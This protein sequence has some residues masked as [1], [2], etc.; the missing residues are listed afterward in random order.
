VALSAG[1][2]LGPYEITAQIGVGGMGVVY[3][4]WDAK[5]QR[6]VAIKLLNAGSGQTHQQRLV[7]E[8]RAAAAL[9]HPHICTVYEV[10]EVAERIFIV[11]ECLEGP[12][13]TDAIRTGGVSTA[14]TIRYGAQIADA[15]SHAH[16][17]GIVH[18][19]IKSG[20]V[21]VLSDHRVKVVDFGLA[22]RRP[23]VDDVTRS[24]VAGDD[25]TIAG[26]LPYM[27][28]E[29]LR[30]MPADSRSDIWSLG[31]VLYEMVCGE[32][33]FTG[34]TGF[35]V[36]AAILEKT[37][38]PL[39]ARVPE[40]VRNVIGG[41]LTKDLKERYQQ[42]RDV[43]VALEALSAAG[44]PG[45]SLEG[46]FAF[47]PDMICI[48]DFDGF[49]RRVNPAWTQTLGWNVDELLSRP[50]FEFIHPDDR[51]ATFREALRMSGTGNKVVS[52]T[53]RYRCRDGSYRWL[54]WSATPLVGD[55]LIYG[56]ARAVTE[57][58]GAEQ[59]SR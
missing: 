35:E 59:E 1:T 28:P 23:S 12:S 21:I 57:P 44:D 20:N 43:R 32:R 9:N 29:V 16:E 5:L 34:G 55:R 58:R 3:R 56:I 39:P 11:M 4:A 30:G 51:N 40:S 49:F 13:L 38:P 19:D 42:A 10:S 26:T 53:N 45:A 6:A 18:R 17:R 31:V 15:L 50:L 54:E 24:R 48:A 8:A 46:L 36:A 22:K 33:P 25:G 2:R 47:S 52:F 14:L 7:A 41:C 37:P 27:A